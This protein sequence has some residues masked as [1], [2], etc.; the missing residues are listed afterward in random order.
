MYVVLGIQLFKKITTFDILYRI[1][2]VQSCWGL[3]KDELTAA[4]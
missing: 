2:G 4:I 1:L 3:K